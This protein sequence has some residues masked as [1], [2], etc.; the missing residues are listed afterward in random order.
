MTCSSGLAADGIP[1]DTGC[2]AAACASGCIEDGCRKSTHFGCSELCQDF[3]SISSTWPAFDRCRLLDGDTQWHDITVPKSLQVKFHQPFK[4]FNLFL[5]CRGLWAS[6][7]LCKPATGVLELD[8]T[9]LPDPKKA[10]LLRENV[11]KAPNQTGLI[12]L[13]AFA[14]QAQ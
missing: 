2:T 1:G 8:A 7:Q 9:L 10:G 5:P 13:L 14:L 3:S 6:V 11:S 4:L 12:G